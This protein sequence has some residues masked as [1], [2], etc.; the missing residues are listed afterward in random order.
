MGVIEKVEEPTDWCS[1]VLVVPKKNNSIRVCID[2][3]KL[4]KAV[5]REFHPLPTTEETISDLGKPKYFS[6]LDANSGYWQMRLRE[7]LQ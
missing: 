1:P 7:E 5:K 2:F 4:N 3:T 6:K